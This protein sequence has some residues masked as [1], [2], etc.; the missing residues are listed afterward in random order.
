MRLL[1][2]DVG[3]GAIAQLDAWGADQLTWLEPGGLSS[4]T[5]VLGQPD[6]GIVVADGA[7]HRIA[8]W[9]GASWSFCGEQGSGVGQFE[10]PTGIASDSSGR[11]YVADTGNARIVRIDDAE[12]S[13][14]VAYG[15]R[16]TSAAESSQPGRFAEPTGVAVGADGRLHVAD[17]HAGRLVSIDGIEGGNWSARPLGGPIAVT[18]RADGALG[19]ALL[20]DRAV[21]MINGGPPQAT[22]AGALGAPL[23]IASLGPE[24]FCC[25]GMGPRLVRLEPAVGELKTVGEWR[26][27]ELG[28]R[29][30][31]GLS[32]V[33][34]KQLIGGL[35]IV[36]LN[37]QCRSW[38]MEAGAQKD[39]TP[40]VNAEDRAR[41][42][43]KR[44][45][46]SPQQ[47]DVACLNEVFNDDARD[48][49]LAP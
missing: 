32:V 16:P 41:L 11:I 30:P 25:D 27:E 15:Q 3:R 34:G 33:E 39:L 4:P 9:D 18:T 7:T 37:T 19:V 17:P 5:G 21:A 31:A 2:S 20:G 47:Y 42:I 36:T 13:G 29:R 40:K 12:G 48:A 28:I 26:L 43:S 46:D 10:R 49:F 35:R 23:A 22:P 38:G 6:G 24:I 8:A 45:L 44:I 14:W 1:V